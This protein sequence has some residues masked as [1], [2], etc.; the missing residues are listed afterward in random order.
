MVPMPHSHPHPTIRHPGAHPPV[1][2][3]ETGKHPCWSLLVDPINKPSHIKI[4]PFCLAVTQPTL[5]GNLQHLCLLVSR[6]CCC[7]TTD[8]CTPVRQRQPR[9]LCLLASAQLTAPASP[10]HFLFATSSHLPS[11]RDRSI[12]QPRPRCSSQS[13]SSS[14]DLPRSSPSSPSLACWPTS[15]TAMSMPMS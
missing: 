10:P 12:H 3:T 9:Q 14:G 2:T 6:G 8:D 7:M 13:A 15:S 11:Q 5:T 1:T 4:K